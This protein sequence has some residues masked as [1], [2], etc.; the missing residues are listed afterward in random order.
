MITSYMYIPT[1]NNLVKARRLVGLADCYA[2]IVLAYNATFL[3][4]VNRTAA[5]R[6]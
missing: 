4:A 3:L 6:L 1:D 5:F 2:V